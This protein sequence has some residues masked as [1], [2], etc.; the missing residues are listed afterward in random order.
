M[1]SSFGPIDAHRS[2]K[3]KSLPIDLRYRNLLR[4]LDVSLF[5]R[6]LSLA[7]SFLIDKKCATNLFY[8]PFLPFPPLPPSISSSLP[9]INDSF[10]ICNRLLPSISF[11]S[12]HETVIEFWSFIEIE[13]RADGCIAVVVWISFSCLFS[14]VK[15]R[16]EARYS[17]WFVAA[18]QVNVFALGVISIGNCWHNY[19]KCRWI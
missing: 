2:S 3:F 11:I 19:S 16:D 9:P 13:I 10:V 8:Q 1:A 6:W 5:A 4:P 7:A 17:N 14:F 15:P 12:S 18:L